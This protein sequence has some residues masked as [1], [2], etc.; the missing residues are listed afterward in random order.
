MDLR[1][2]LSGSIGSPF[3]FSG[4]QWGVCFWQWLKAGMVDRLLV[5]EKQSENSEATVFGGLVFLI[6]V[7]FSRQENF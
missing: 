5:F 6:E 2:F 1:K 4:F 3:C 7:I